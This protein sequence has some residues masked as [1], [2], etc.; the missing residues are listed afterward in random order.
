[1]HEPHSLG[2]F[3]TALEVQM[4]LGTPCNDPAG[5][6]KVKFPSIL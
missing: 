3:Q 1:M 5:S 4:D 6:N 2:S